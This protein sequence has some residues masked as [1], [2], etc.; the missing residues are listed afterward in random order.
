MNAL[1]IVISGQGSVRGFVLCARRHEDNGDFGK[2][3]VF[4][5]ALIKR[6]ALI[7]LDKWLMM[8]KA[9]AEEF[10]VLAQKVRGYTQ[11]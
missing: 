2:F 3:A 8:Q 11:F 10:E 6:A 1:S 5:V 4:I 7:A 9:A